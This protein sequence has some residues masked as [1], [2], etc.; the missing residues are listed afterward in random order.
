MLHFNLVFQNIGGQIVKL[1]TAIIS[2]H[3]VLIVAEETLL[4]I[5]RLAQML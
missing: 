1:E 2:N 5:Y 4:S 3:D